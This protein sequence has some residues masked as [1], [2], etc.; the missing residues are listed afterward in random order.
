[1]LVPR[2]EVDPLLEEPSFEPNK[3]AQVSW[4]GGVSWSNLIGPH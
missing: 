4:S 2:C 1:M 3:S